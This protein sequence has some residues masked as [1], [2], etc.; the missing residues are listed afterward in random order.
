MLRSVSNALKFAAFVAVAAVAMPTVSFSQEKK[1]TVMMWGT[2]WQSVFKDL[3]EG[4]A[5][6]TGI[7]VDVETQTSSGEGLV[8]LQAM[9][10][11]PT[12][13]VWF[14]TLSVASRAANDKELFSELPLDKM[15]NVSK[16]IPGS[17][18][19]NWAAVATFPIVLLYRPDL[20]GQVPASWEDLWKPIYRN[21]LAVPN[22]SMYSARMLL[23]SGTL[24]GGNERNIDP[25]FEKLKS[26]RPNV[27]MFYASD[28]QAR[29]ALAQGEVAAIV[30]PPVHLRW[31]NEQGV[32]AKAA[33]LRTAPLEFDVVMLP[34]TGKEEMGAA[35]I[36]YVLRK[37]INEA[38]VGKR[39]M[40]PINTEAKVPEALQ[41]IMPN[42]GDGL[43]FDENVVTQNI[44]AWTERFNR[45]IA[46]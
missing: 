2:T 17:V 44:A 39:N 45:E 22:M 24:A 16:A 38:M 15:N 29:Q 36:N 10:Q 8:K 18:T 4:F 27:A 32:N 23:L 14:T 34:R 5:K 21:K 1:I 41:G 35:Y 7:K 6:E 31:L 46:K 12:I 26:L 42:T 43:L 37:D 20:I 3:S 11:K 33:N 40:G 9:R 28:A 30:A 25:A 13:D 19:K